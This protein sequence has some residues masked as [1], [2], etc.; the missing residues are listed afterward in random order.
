MN[1]VRSWRNRARDLRAEYRH[2]DACGAFASVR[3]LCCTHCGAGMEMASDV[4][5]PRVMSAIAFSH[6]HLVVET[7]DQIGNLKPV[8][9]MRAQDGHHFAL[10]LCEAD[11]NL[12]ARLVGESLQLVVRRSG[13]E[14][15]ADEAIAY[16]RKVASG[17]NTRARLKRNEAKSK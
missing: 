6:A 10:P 13:T 5:L 14:S 8:M 7:M 15:R 1:V 11:A 2:C 3:R 4:P 12:G 17:A 9:L 16:V